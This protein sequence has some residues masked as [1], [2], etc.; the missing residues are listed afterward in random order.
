MDLTGILEI[1]GTTDTGKVRSQNEDSIGEELELGT[2]VLADGMG[3]Y[4]GGEVASAIAV[5]TILHHLHDHLPLVPPSATDRGTGFYG[6]SLVARNAIAEAN[7][8]IVRAAEAQS[9]YR[10]MGTTVVLGVFFDNKL[11][12]A[13]VGDSRMYRIRDGV[14]EQLTVDH[15]LLQELVDKGFYTEKEAR[16]SLNKNLVTR[17]LGIELDVKIDV[18]ELDTLPGD[19]YLLCS[20]GLCDMITDEEIL[21][22]VKTF[23]VNLQETA[24]N[25]VRLANENGGR[26]NVSVL[27]ARPLFAYPAPP[28]PRWYQKMFGVLSRS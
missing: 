9:Q 11:A 21:L 17:A 14:L 25:L 2:V 10:G 13:H 23:A 24:D 12:V 6:E 28:P 5:N 4:H 15:T 18:R 7:H 16:E 20:D 3:G 26:D 27:L 19:I 22:T 8:A 1:A